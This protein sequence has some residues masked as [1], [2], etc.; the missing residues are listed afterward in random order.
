MKGNVRLDIKNDS[1]HD[2]IIDQLEFNVIWL[3]LNR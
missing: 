1:H 3:I 2:N